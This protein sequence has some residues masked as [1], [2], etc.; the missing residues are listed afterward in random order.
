MKLRINRPAPTS[1]TIAS[2]TLRGDEHALREMTTAH[3]PASA[4]RQRIGGI[5]ACRLHGWRKGEEQRRRDADRKRE[6]DETHIDVE[7]G[8]RRQLCRRAAKRGDTP[9][10]DEQTERR[11]GT[12]EQQPF[13][14]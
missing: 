8:G 4:S 13:A 3:L 7:V 9:V 14:E 10:R 2:A 12:R 5:A 1:N 11:A 6:G